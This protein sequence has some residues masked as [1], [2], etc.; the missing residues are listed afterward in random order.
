M[1]SNQQLIVNH[2]YSKTQ[3]LEIIIQSSFQD[4][5]SMYWI[6]LFKNFFRKKNLQL[7]LEKISRQS[8]QLVLCKRIIY[9]HFK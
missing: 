3:I 6:Q 8:K 9:K 2:C 1:F 7:K 5:C 4:K